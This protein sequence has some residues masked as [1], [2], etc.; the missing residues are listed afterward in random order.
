MNNNIKAIQAHLIDILKE[1]KR[2]CNLNGIQYT[3]IAGSALG[4]YRHEGFI[5]WDDDVDIGMIRK[6]YEKFIKACEKDLNNNSFYIQTLHNTPNY[7]WGYAKIR[8]KGT[9]LQRK[10]QEHLGYESGVFIDIF[11]LDSVPESYIARKLFT[12][13][14]YFLRK[15]QWSEV[16]KIAESNS[17][18]KNIYK[19]VSLYANTERIIKRY[20]EIIEKSAKFNSPYVRILTFPTVSLKKDYYRLEWYVDTKLSKFNSVLVP[21]PKKI[22]EYLE[23]KFGEYNQ[24]PPEENRKGHD[25]SKIQV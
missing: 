16:G 22:E 2:I 11:P 25:F 18:K 8:K 3:L 21:I 7:R 5:P 10:N 9:I 15:L 1:V 12:F 6:E 24:L 14:C 13:E 17:I 20:D 23:F 4:A 19:M